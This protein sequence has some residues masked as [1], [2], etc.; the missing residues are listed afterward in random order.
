MEENVPSVPDTEEVPDD[1]VLGAYDYCGGDV[2]FC[3]TDTGDED[4]WLAVGAGTEVSL[5]EWL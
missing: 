5:D 4:R 2:L 3:V 1:E